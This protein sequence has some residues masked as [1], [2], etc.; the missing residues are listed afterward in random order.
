MSYKFVKVK[1][2]TYNFTYESN[3][4]KYLKH[5]FGNFDLRNIKLSDIQDYFNKTKLAKSTM[6]KQRIIINDMFEKAIINDHCYK[7]PI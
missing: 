5:Y 4:D 1:E 2:H 7:N 6:L 3:I